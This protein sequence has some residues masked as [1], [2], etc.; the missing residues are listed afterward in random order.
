MLLCT[1]L[2]IFGRK[3]KKFSDRLDKMSLWMRVKSPLRIY[4]F[5][6]TIDCCARAVSSRNTCH[7]ANVIWV[8]EKL[9]TCS[10][11]DDR[12]SLSISCFLRLHEYFK[13]TEVKRNS[14]RIQTPLKLL[15][16]CSSLVCLIST[17]ECECKR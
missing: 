6:A 2:S 11:N 3:T 12:V 10:F 16:I 17:S 7:L 15:S 5:S 13:R 9:D 8:V 1:C 14:R 4:V